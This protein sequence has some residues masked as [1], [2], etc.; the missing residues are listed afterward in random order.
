MTL[1]NE[2]GREL[3]ASELVPATVVAIQPPEQDAY[4]TFWVSEVTADT[5]MFFAGVANWYVL[6]FVRP[7]GT[8]WDDKGRQVH[9]FE[10]LGKI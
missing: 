8:I 6:N 3:K 9:V 5:A 2:I 4:L 1:V 7:D 10:Y